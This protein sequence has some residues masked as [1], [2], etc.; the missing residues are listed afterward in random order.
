MVEQLSLGI[1]LFFCTP[2]PCGSGICIARK[3]RYVQGASWLLYSAGQAAGSGSAPL[4]GRCERKRGEG[5]RERERVVPDVRHHFN[6]PFYLP[7]HPSKL[8]APPPPAKRQ[9]H[10]REE[11]MSHSPVSHL[12]R[13]VVAHVGMNGTTQ[14]NRAFTQKEKR[15]STSTTLT[16]RNTHNIMLTL[17]L[18]A[19]AHGARGG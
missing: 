12:S 19:C 3:P 5:L 9:P 6:L 4:S 10:A 14:E 18:S 7:I 13:H 1:Q 2:T 17:S 15:E 11:T 16:Q 8:A